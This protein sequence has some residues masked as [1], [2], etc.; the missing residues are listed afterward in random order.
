MG[1]SIYP[2]PF[3]GIQETIVDAKGDIIAATAADTPARLAVGT[4]GQTLVADSS[5]ATG[6][7]WKTDPVADLVTTA[8]DTLYATAADTL[9]RLGIGTAGQVLQVNSGATAPE[10]VTPTGGSTFVGCFIY[11]S[12]LSTVSVPDNTSVVIDLPDELYDTNGFHSTTTNT[13][14][15]TVPA[16]QAG[17]YYIE[18]KLAYQPGSQT[19]L[20]TLL[21]VS[22]NGIYANAMDGAG[23]DFNSDVPAATVY[24]LAEGD[25]V[26]IQAR[27]IGGGTQTV[28]RGNE[29]ETS[30]MIA[31]LGA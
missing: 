13:S 14:R 10:W 28:K 24:Y 21:K 4:N 27:Q 19:K 15:I 18:G 17:Y 12:G 7:V 23:G 26:E 1:S 25:Y 16:G 31:K 5:T 3:S 8:G 6:L 30:L 11:G 29:T 9:A 22:G 2:V 20:S